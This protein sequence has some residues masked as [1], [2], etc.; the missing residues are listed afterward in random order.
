M[1]S[2]KKIGVRL[3]EVSFRKVK[4]YSI[5]NDIS[6]SEIICTLLNKTPL[7]LKTRQ[8]GEVINEAK[9]KG[10]VNIKMLALFP[11]DKIILKLKNMCLKNNTSFSEIVRNL[12]H[13]A[14]FSEFDFKTKGQKITESKK[15]KK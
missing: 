2:Y 8:I 5:M 3:D 7:I 12:I 15:K 4:E 1:K 9:E 14:N 6:M 13:E 10:N 11:S